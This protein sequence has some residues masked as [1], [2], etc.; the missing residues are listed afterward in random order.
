MGTRVR[1]KSGA[2]QVSLANSLGKSSMFSVQTK[3]R[4]EF[5]RS[6]WCRSLT[7]YAI[8]R[9]VF[10]LYVLT[11]TLYHYGHLAKDSCHHLWGANTLL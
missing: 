1:S 9:L 4:R 11:Y 5:T 2:S 3:S 6:R 7:L 8:W 10:L